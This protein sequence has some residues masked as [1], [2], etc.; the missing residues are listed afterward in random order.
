MLFRA[1]LLLSFACESVCALAMLIL[2]SPAKNLNFDAAPGAPRA[3]KPVF[4]KDAA[5]LSETTR[6]LTR[7]KIKSL[8][9]ISEKLAD[10]NYERFQAFDPKGKS[11]S[12]KQAALAFNGDV[13]LGLD[14][15][16]LSNDDLSFAQ[17][18]VRILSGLYGLL[19]PLDAIQPYRLEMG[20]RLKTPRGAN[21]YDFW[22]DKI[23]REID[24]AVKA[25]KDPT[26]VNLASN[27]YF[28]A[29]DRKALK[30]PVVTP[31]FKDVKDGEAKIISFFAKRARGMMARWAAEN[32]IERAEDLKD[33]AVEGYAFRPGDSKDDLWVFSRPQP[34]PKKPAP[35]KAAAKKAAPALV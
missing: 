18:H 33:F 28:G 13:Y 4:L 23:S 27:E 1:L 30:A 8:M 25:H 21:L 15:A 12:A 24:K 17:D 7:G 2:L 5:E 10:L 14:A 26:V 34:A 29:V 22:G 31:V 9:G 35:K 11:E 6:K 32:R 19:R 20:S 3:T 16:S